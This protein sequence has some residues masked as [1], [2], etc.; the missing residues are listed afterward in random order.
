MKKISAEIENIEVVIERDEE[1]DV[2]I[3]VV[4]SAVAS[5]RTISFLTPLRRQDRQSGTLC[6]KLTTFELSGPC[7]G[8]H[9]E[10]SIES[11]FVLDGVDLENFWSDDEPLECVR[12]FGASYAHEAVLTSRPSQKRVFDRASQNLML[13]RIDNVRTTP[14]GAAHSR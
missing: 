12:V 5:N 2:F 7:S 13:E 3:R 11:E 6:L 4:A 9:F 1:T 14:L 10:T 8:E